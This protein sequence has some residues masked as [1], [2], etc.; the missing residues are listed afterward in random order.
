MHCVCCV[1][2]PLDNFSLLSWSLIIGACTGHEGTLRMLLGRG[3]TLQELF[4]KTVQEVLELSDPGDDGP[5]VLDTVRA[6][7]C[8]HLC[9][10]VRYA[11]RKVLASKAESRA[12]HASMAQPVMRWRLSLPAPGGDVKLLRVV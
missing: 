4:R 1:T 10:A 8:D 9:P 6:P 11:A 5:P 12:A 7:L 2:G 3:S